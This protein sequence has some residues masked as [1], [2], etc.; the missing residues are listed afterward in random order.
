MNR[1]SGRLGLMFLILIGVG[2]ALAQELKYVEYD[3][4]LLLGSVYKARRE[5][6]MREIGEDGIAI[7]YS[8]PERHRNGDVEYPYRQDDN[9]Y[10]LTG[11][12][13]PNA[14]LVLV[15]NGAT[16]RKD[17]DSTATTS[18]REI[19]FVQKRDPFREQWTGRR[20]GPAGAMKLRGLEYGATNDQ[21]R[22]VLSR[23][24]TSNKPKYIY[25]PDFR[26][27][28]TG[29]IAQLLQPVRELTAQKDAAVEV[30]DPS[31]I[32]RKMRIIKSPEEI[33]YLTK[34]TEISVA[35]HNQAMMSCEPGMHEYEL[36]AVYEYVYRK[37]GAESGG[38]PCIVGA[39]ENSVILHYDKVRRPINNGDIVLADCAA[40]YRGY[41][42]DVTRTFPANGTFSK[43]QRE[44][45]QIVLDAE[46]A[47]IAA[48]RPGVEWRAVSSIVDSVTTEGLMKLGLM[49]SRERRELR[50]FLMHGVG[51]PVGLNVHDVG[52]P[53][54]EAGMV[55]TI[56]PGIYIAEG[57]EGVDPGYYNIGVR[58][59]DT[60]L[61]TPTGNKVLSAGSPRE[62]A[63]IEA[64]MK[65]RGIGNEPVQ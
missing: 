55:H 21:F 32:V 54:L 13:E 62:I 63:E 59:E 9:L 50:R 4:D 48:M 44:I 64:M 39:A 61:I 10:Y 65:K 49:K 45:Y 52:Q 8:A 36:A 15:P 46:K 34:A 2:S 16:M 57:M 27:D 11:F 38:Y 7:F 1:L 53:I 5:R 12:T 58:V 26:L 29:T 22:P 40:E 25:V 31:T 33:E 17:D 24:M 56:E 6:V 18:T 47:A 51:H 20:Y 28:F 3:T 35:A 41:S 43:P 42:S 37:L 19:L 14:I 60:V 30:K 23:L